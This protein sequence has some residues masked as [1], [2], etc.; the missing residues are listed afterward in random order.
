[1]LPAAS[2][3]FRAVDGWDYGT[4][5]PISPMSPIGPIRRFSPN[6][7]TV[8]GAT[9]AIAHAPKETSSHRKTRR[10][11]PLDLRLSFTSTR[12]P[13]AASAFETYYSE[14]P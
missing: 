13:T 7:A 14:I 8:Q 10:P 2:G 5:P 11:N 6:V 1:M 12:N 4:G 9:Y 3:A